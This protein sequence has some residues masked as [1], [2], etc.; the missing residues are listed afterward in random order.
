MLTDVD[1][2]SS[3]SRF[4]DSVVGFTGQKTQPK[5]SKYWRTP[6]TIIYMETVYAIHGVQQ[7]RPQTMTAT[8]NDHDGHKHVFWKTVWP[9][10]H[11]EFDDFL[12]VSRYFFTSSLLWTSRYTPCGHHGLWPSWY[13]PL[14]INQIIHE[15]LKLS[16]YIVRLHQHTISL[17]WSWNDSE[18]MSIC[19][20]YGWPLADYTSLSS[21]HCLPL[22]PAF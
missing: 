3:Y 6:S 22:L 12:E 19:Q 11:H 15:L 17:S 10:I 18:Q 20:C 14:F 2:L 16:H 4:S 5:A 8:N 21:S 13:R 9:W 1:K 7:W